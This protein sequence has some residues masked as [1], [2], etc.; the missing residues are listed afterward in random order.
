[1]K[2]IF[3][4]ILAFG[5]S[6]SFKKDLNRESNVKSD[7]QSLQ[8][9]ILSE[10]VE[11][12]IIS[13]SSFNLK[14]DRDFEHDG[15]VFQSALVR[16]N[17][18]I[19]EALI[20]KGFTPYQ[21]HYQVFLENNKYDLRGFY[22][23]KSLNRKISLEMQKALSHSPSKGM[24]ELVSINKISCEALLS[25]HLEFS[26]D[27]TISSN[28]FPGEDFFEV[29]DIPQRHDNLL[30]FL[31][32]KNCTA[33]NKLSS[34]KSI[35]ISSE[36]IRALYQKDG[37]K[38]SSMFTYLSELLGNSRLIFPYQ[39]NEK[40][41]IEYFIQ[42]QISLSKDEALTKE[43]L[44]NL[45]LKPFVIASR[46]GMPQQSLRSDDLIRIEETY[47]KKSNPEIKSPDYLEN[48]KTAFTAN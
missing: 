18:D 27:E 38:Y 37:L 31:N 44:T 4:L 24:D 26:L 13:I 34:A 42:Y 12:A 17:P 15:E 11:N 1:M 16:G 19:V 48:I 7:V 46:I 21:S 3:F 45:W 28:Y 30:K 41:G 35:W 22:P 23:L 20:K 5:C 6:C 43:D 9:A 25:L 33:R 29:S 14:E 47:L 10:S 32:E 39:G 2:K 36:L 40:V 8:E